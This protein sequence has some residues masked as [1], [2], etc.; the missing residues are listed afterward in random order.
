ML[1][2]TC[3]NRQ[4]CKKLCADAESY[5]N[6]DHVK[7]RD[8]P[9]QIEHMANTESESVWDMIESEPQT[10]KQQIVTAIIRVLP[11]QQHIAE[12]VGVSRQYVSRVIS[13]IRATIK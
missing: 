9:C 6:Q 10:T 5:V 7:M 4:N 8:F 3:K 11:P 2:L 13:E 1:C 12:Q